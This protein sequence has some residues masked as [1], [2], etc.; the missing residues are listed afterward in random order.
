LTYE[1][2]YRGMQGVEE[3]LNHRG[4]GRKAEIKIRWDNGWETWRPLNLMKE[5]IPDTVAEYA[6]ANDLVNETEWKWAKVYIRDAE[7]VSILSHRFEGTEGGVRAEVHYDGD[8]ETTWINAK[9]IDVDVLAKYLYDKDISID[10]QE[11]EWL[12]FAITASKGNWLEAAQDH[13]AD[14]AH[15]TQHDIQS[16]ME[17]IRNGSG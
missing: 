5:E 3:V 1:T 15:V 6:R 11:W 10:N 13:I 16:R 17:T 14:V 8:E 7:I 12:K 4:K 2:I 9:T